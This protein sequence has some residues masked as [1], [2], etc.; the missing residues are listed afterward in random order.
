MSIIHKDIKNNLFSDIN[1]SISNKLILKNNR[2]TVFERLNNSTTRSKKIHLYQPKIKVSEIFF[3]DQASPQINIKKARESYLQK[4]QIRK[5][6]EPPLN[7]KLGSLNALK[8]RIQGS[9]STSRSRNLRLNSDQL[10]SG[11]NKILVANHSKENDIN[12]YP[13]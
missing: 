1:L 11:Y 3:H 5:S 13:D 8:S 4:I 10:G 2:L 9:I 6:Q 12:V 7:P